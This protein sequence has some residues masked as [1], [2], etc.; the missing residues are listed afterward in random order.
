[1]KTLNP[2]QKYLKISTSVFVFV[3][4]WLL[5]YVATGNIQADDEAKK[6]KADKIILQ[7]TDPKSE[8]FWKL[9]SELTKLDNT[10]VP[11]LLEEVKSKDAIQRLGI[12]KALYELDEK[13]ESISAL[14]K[15]LEEDDEDLRKICAELISSLVYRDDNYGKKEKIESVIEDIL[16]ETKNRST[17]ISL[18]KALYTVSGST[19]ATDALKEFLKDKDEKISE[20]AVF[21]LAEID[22][23]NAIKK[24]LKEMSKSP[25][26]KGR[27]AKMYLLQN[28]LLEDI[29]RELSHSKGEKYPILDEII[30]IILD[31]YID[32]KEI[33]VE[34]LIIS[35]ARG[36]ANSLDPYSSY[37]DEKDYTKL[38]QSINLDYGGIGAYVSQRDNVM[39]IERPVYGGPA[40]KAG[41]RSLDKIIEIEGKSTIGEDLDKLIL[42][43]KGKPNTSVKVKI[44]RRG[45]TEPRE[46]VLIREQIKIASAKGEL[47]PGDIGYI[48]VTSFGETTA[49]ELSNTI[50]ELK[51]NGA[52]SFII[53]LRNNH[54]GYLNAAIDVTELFLPK[55]LE[56]V[57]VKGPKENISYKAKNAD[58]ISEPIV[59]L[60]D[61]GTASA[62]EIFSGALKDHKYATLVGTKTYGKGSVQTL[63]K[64]SSTK[65]KTALRLTVSKYYLPSGKSIH[66]GNNQEGGIEPDIKVED[67]KR[68]FW[69]DWESARLLDTGELDKFVSNLWGQNPELA[70]KL[71]KFDELKLENYPAANELYNKLETKLKE[72]EFREILRTH[73]RR[74]VADEE[75]KEFLFDYEQ[76]LQLQSAILELLKKTSRDVKSISE[77]NFLVNK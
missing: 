29:T 67:E 30:E 50:K 14:L 66:K 59:L 68:D 61:E 62:A 42:M 28:K 10:I 75:K 47:L 74:K 33:N 63:F 57:S 35:A 24:R 58:S 23:F 48:I 25:T 21:A 69:K 9:S 53:D 16:D 44:L 22:Q 11:Y 52:K 3:N 55:G 1:M 2:V 27:R 26:E 60:V 19:R 40:Y 18:C 77:Y 39:T 15:V 31:N 72:N 38:T 45:W 71:A 32:E 65:N 43:L 4:L 13:G 5:F 51:Q 8:E 64:L 34:K 49:V 56:I 6:Q 54:G 12:C 17:K 37:L 76:D 7:L 46:F 73:L 70:K 36:I 41:L 20:E